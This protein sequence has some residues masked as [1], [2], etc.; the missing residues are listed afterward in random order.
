M[1]AVNEVRSVLFYFLR[2]TPDRPRQF[3][4]AED[5]RSSA[6]TALENASPHDTTLISRNLRRVFLHDA[7]LYGRDLTNADLRG[8][9]LCT[10]RLDYSVLRGANLSGADLAG[11]S[12]VNACLTGADLSYASFVGADLSD[13]DLTGTMSRGAD[14]RDATLTNTRFIGAVCTSARFGGQD[15]ARTDFSGA[16]MTE[17]RFSPAFW[18]E[19]V[20]FEMPISFSHGEQCI[21]FV[22]GRVM[23]DARRAPSLSDCITHIAE[24]ARPPANEPAPMKADPAARTINIE[25]RT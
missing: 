20:I 23:R 4:L 19:Q 5:E 9:S 21:S 8:A 13:A 6:Y 25:E 18:E 10:C 12:L 24:G 14:F 7:D 17:L 11:A 1:A 22:N 2:K 15:L 16:V 3:V